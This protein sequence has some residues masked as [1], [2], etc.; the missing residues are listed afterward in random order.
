M[1]QTTLKFAVSSVLFLALLSGCKVQVQVPDNGRVETASGNYQCEASQTCEIEVTDLLFNETFVA[2]PADGFQFDGWRQEALYLCGGLAI[3]CPLVTSG[4]EGIEILMDIL[5]SDDV[6]FLEPVFKVCDGAC[7]LAAALSSDHTPAN[8][9]LLLSLIENELESEPFYLVEYWRLDQHNPET[10]RLLAQYDDV[11]ASQLKLVG[12][13][14][15]VDNTVFRQPNMHEGRV[16][17]RVRVIAYPSPQAFLDVIQDTSYQEAIQLKHQATLALQSLWVKTIFATP[18]IDTFPEKDEFY[19]SNLLTRR[20]MALYPDGTSQDLTGAEA[21]QLYNEVVADIFA[22]IGAY[23]AFSGSVE[24]LVLGT[25]DEWEIYNL[26]YYPSL[27]DLITMTTDPRWQA[28]HP[29]KDA[30]LSRNSVMMTSPLIEPQ[31]P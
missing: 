10:G 18:I 28:A 30:G 27:P 11:L 17:N 3:P 19:N 29:N 13:R 25:D 16:W 6:W 26:V 2:E 24:H 31:M 8:E 20:E 14:I 15:A 7:G 23:A 1:I 12:A 22:E 5:T 21:Q 9:A 4:F